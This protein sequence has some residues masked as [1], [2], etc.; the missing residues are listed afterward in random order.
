MSEE[1]KDNEVLT[2]SEKLP[3][4]TAELANLDLN[5]RESV[6]KFA[7]KLDEL[8]SEIG[9][10]DDGKL[11]MVG[12]RNFFGNPHI[13]SPVKMWRH[14]QS[15]PGIVT[16][17]KTLAKNADTV[18]VYCTIG[19]TD[20]DEFDS[21]YAFGRLATI[22]GK[23]KTMLATRVDEDRE[24]AFNEILASC[25]NEV[26]LADH[27]K[28]LERYE[29]LPVPTGQNN[30]GSG[31]ETL[32]YGKADEGLTEE[33]LQGIIDQIATKTSHVTLVRIIASSLK[34]PD[35]LIQLREIQD[36]V[37]ARIK[38]V[39]GMLSD[40]AQ[41]EVAETE[42][43]KQALQDIKASETAETDVSR[44]LPDQVIVGQLTELATA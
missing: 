4:Y 20:L 22:K 37:S 10:G 15:L 27:K 26:S 24:I 7:K 41:D 17:A 28:V 5:T 2:A 14:L 38:T 9:V 34:D 23:V 35:G 3:V 42:A 21:R 32:E 19:D 25:K 29:M 39:E 11:D 8:V 1:T 36:I 18:N 40:A 30:T 6:F 43:R 16:D 13:D 12:A 31:E 33:K 44:E